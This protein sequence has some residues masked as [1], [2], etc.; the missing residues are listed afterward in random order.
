MIKAKLFIV[1]I[2]VLMSAIRGE[3]QN[4][5][6]KKPNILVLLTDDQ[7]YNT[8]HALGNA[9]IITPNMD[10]LAKEGMAFTQAHI[11]GGMGG[12]ICCPSRAMLMSGRSLFHVHQDGEYIPETDVTFPELFRK[13]GYVTFE[14]GKWHQDKASF[15]RSF[16]T[17]DNIFFG[18]MHPPATGGQYRP[19]LNHYDPSGQYEKSFWGEEFSSVY[20]S[21][22]AVN[23]LDKQKNDQQPFLMYVAFTS[24]HDPRTPPTW[25]GHSYTPD[26]VPLPASFMPNPL[27]N[28]ELNIRDET[29]LPYPRTKPAV[30]RELAKYYSMISEVDFQIGRILDELKKTGKYDNT[31]IVFAG[32]NGLAVGDHGLLGKQNCYESAI[33]V[34]FIFSGPG[35]P[36]NKQSDKLVYLNDLYPTLCELVNIKIPAT[37][38]TH[39]LAPAFGNG[40]FKGRDDV[41]FAYSNLQRAFVKDNFKLICYNVNGTCRTE[42]FDLKADPVELHDLAALPRYKDKV[43]AMTTLLKKDLQE[44]ND[45]CDL[46]ASGWGHPKKW[47]W[48]EIKKLNP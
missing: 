41:F 1:S 47:S 17:G 9:A 4:T 13:N 10:R 48:D 12:A 28:G 42:L 36:K 33:R 8:I 35:I 31:I 44:H 30:K 19:K 20:F 39:S 45:F 24:P 21:D 32:D 18:G 7:R 34:P 26:D 23:F 46:D 29:L 38:E 43:A 16:T 5:H 3:A 37:V 22:A 6:S 15:N 11:M 40:N 2:V 14:T 25:Y 27:D